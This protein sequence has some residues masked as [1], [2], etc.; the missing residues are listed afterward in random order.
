MEQDLLEIGKIVSVH[1]I[2]GDVKV[3]PWCDEPAFLTEFESLYLKGEEVEI[4]KARVQ[5]NMVLLK[6]AGVNTP[7]D[8]QK[9]VGQIL[10]IHRDWVELPEGTYFIAD[11]IG[12]TVVDADDQTV[13]YGTLTDVS[14]TGANDVY[15]IRFADGKTRYVPAIPDVVIETDLE[16]KVMRIRPLKGLFED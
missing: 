10:W 11:L 14:Q 6:I 7:E 4:E 12:L 1:G 9:L 2:R 13:T 15:H 8:A 5:K 16:N 3:Q